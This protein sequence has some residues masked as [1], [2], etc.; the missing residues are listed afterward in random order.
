MSRQHL[1]I[2]NTLD[3][4]KILRKLTCDQNVSVIMVTHD[5]R[6]LPYCDRVMTIEHKKV[7]FKE[8]SKEII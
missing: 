6:M 2:W 1:W 4:M 3:L 7:I 5:T 8:S